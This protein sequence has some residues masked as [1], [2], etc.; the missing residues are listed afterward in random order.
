MSNV[1]PSEATDLREEN[2]APT[3]TSQN[4]ARHFQV[5][6]PPYRTRLQRTKVGGKLFLL[7]QALTNYVPSLYQGRRQRMLFQDIRTYCLFIGHGRSGHS[8]FGALLDAHPNAVLADEVD[9]LFFLSAGFSRDQI[10]AL[11]M[12]RARLLAKHKRQKNGREGKTYSYWVPGQ[13]QGRF[14]TLHVI[15]D[16]KAGKS[17]QRLAENPTLLHRLRDITA[18][19][20]LKVIHVVRNPYDN[21]ST[22]MLRGYRGFGEAIGH[23]FERCESIRD[24][25]KEI[26]DSDLLIIRQEDF[27]AQPKL[28]LSEACHF[29][30]L[31]AMTDYLNDCASI[32]YKSPAKSRYKVPWSSKLIEDA[33]NRIEEFDFLGG[34]SYES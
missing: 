12:A 17:A 6:R 14:K 27:I 20:T 15:G 18:D 11:I 33:Q 1:N 13:W 34:Y 30:G 25:R 2:A 26:N 31:E 5:Q 16:S 9:T 10:Y 28:W 29:L 24:I 3:A 23:Y 7:K 8:I 19:S 22:D 21:I 4:G 32:V